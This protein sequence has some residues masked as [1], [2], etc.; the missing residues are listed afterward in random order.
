MADSLNLWSKKEAAEIDSAAKWARQFLASTKTFINDE[1]HSS[2]DAHYFFSSKKP[3]PI[4]AMV[5]MFEELAPDP[6]FDDDADLGLLLVVPL[7][8]TASL[9]SRPPLIP[10]L[11]RQTWRKD[12][13]PT[14]YIGHRG[15][16]DAFDNVEERR[17]PLAWSSSGSPA[18]IYFRTWR[19]DESEADSEFESAVYFRYFAD[20]SDPL[21]LYFGLPPV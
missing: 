6:L 13:L 21:R 18:A 11:L 19:S 8:R 16:F 7:G 15:A 3:R 14:L 12:E 2:A 20:E 17:T 10:D 1:L 9:E 5:K 4:A